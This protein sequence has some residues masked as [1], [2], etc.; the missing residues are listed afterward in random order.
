MEYEVGKFYN[1]RCAKLLYGH[2]G[3]RE[4]VPI[5]GEVHKDIQIGVS[6]KH[7][8]VDGRFNSSFVNNVGLTNQ[9]LQYDKIEG[10]ESYF[11]EIVFK[12]RKCIRAMTGLCPPNRYERDIFGNPKAEKYYT[13]VDSMIGKSCKGKK[14]PHLGTEMLVRDG[15]LFCPLHN[16]V[17]NI[18]KE[19]I[20]KQ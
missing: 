8:H 16:L 4:F 20:I 6:W 12:R 18:E 5:L 2:G 15:K 10:F 1:V 19:I 13:W 7:I 17:G 3:F 14:C 11:T 9:I